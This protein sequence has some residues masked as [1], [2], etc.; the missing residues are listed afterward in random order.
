MPCRN[1]RLNCSRRDFL[2]RGAALAA[3]LPFISPLHSAWA[4]APGPARTANVA[5]SRCRSYSPAE[6]RAALSQCLDAIGGVGKLVRDKTVTVKLNLTGTDFSPYLGRPVG[7]TFMTHHATVMALLAIFFDAGA[8]R[9]RLVESPQAE[10]SNDNQGQQ[11]DGQR[12]EQAS[13]EGHAVTYGVYRKNL[14]A[15]SSS[16]DR[17]I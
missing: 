10:T 7:E 9:V 16:A 17:S 8:K 4:D 13:G 14:S 6:T 11:G 15:R 2:R 1:D 5:I 12:E 3:G